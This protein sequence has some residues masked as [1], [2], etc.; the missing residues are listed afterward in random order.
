MID[1]EMIFKDRYYFSE[2]QELAIMSEIYEKLVVNI[3]KKCIYI[4]IYIYV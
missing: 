1:M 3:I 2:G 4:Y